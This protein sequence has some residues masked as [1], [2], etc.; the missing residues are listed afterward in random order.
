MVNKSSTTWRNLSPQ[1]KTPGSDAEWKLLLQRI[2]AADPA[3]GGRDRGWRDIAGLQRQR[4]SSSCS[5]RVRP[6]AGT[7]HERSAEPCQASLIAARI[8]HAGRCRLPGA[9]RR[10]PGTRRLRL[11][12]LR[13]GDVDNLW[14]THGD[15]R[16]R[17]WCCSAT[18]TSCRRAARGM[19]E[20]SVRARSPRWQSLRP[21]RRG[22]ERRRRRVRR[23]AGAFRRRASRP[24]P[25]RSRC[26]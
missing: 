25:A 16:A 22:H 4:R 24:S 13:F 10:S 12:A 8:D 14:A 17:C 6:A 1:R 9:D 11:R 2:S 18:P 20:R 3:A 23:R 7:T 5:V 21:R 15:G 19:D 26:C